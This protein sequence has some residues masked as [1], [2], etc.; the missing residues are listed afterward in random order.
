MSDWIVKERMMI[1]WCA[2]EHDIVDG[3]VKYI[4]SVIFDGEKGHRPMRGSSPDALPYYWGS[5][6]KECQEVCDSA[7]EEMGVDK[8]TAMK[9]VGRSMRP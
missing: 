4:P 2:G 9:I 1:Y 6:E 5:T 7:N 3:E 8:E